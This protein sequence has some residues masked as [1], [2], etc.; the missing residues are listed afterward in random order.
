MTTSGYAGLL[1]VIGSLVFCVGAGIGV[2]RVH[3][4]PDP[5]AR[6]RMLREGAVAWRVAQPFYVAG[7]LIAAVGVGVLVAAVPSGAERV[8][9]TVS[10]ALV[11]VGALSWSW[12]VYL[13]TLD[14]EAFSLRALP[15]WPFGSYVWLTLVGL[16]LL[17]CG[18][19]I[20]DYAAWIGSV[21]L[22]GAIGLG[23]LYLGTGDLPPFTFYVLFTLVG[24]GLLAR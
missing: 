13:R 10:A 15:A 7:P 23:L 4:E 8:L 11:L 6:L 21:T 5:Q 17:G 22:V 19:L 9:V 20:G 2:P 18:L 14:V 1:L 3:T 12:V 24:A 16:V